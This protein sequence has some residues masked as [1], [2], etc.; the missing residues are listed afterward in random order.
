MLSTQ[1]D[2]S[3]SGHKSCFLRQE[4]VVGEVESGHHSYSDT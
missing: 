1:V 3:G 4:E 2:L